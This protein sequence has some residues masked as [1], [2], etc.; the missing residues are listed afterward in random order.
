MEQD[1]AQGDLDRRQKFIEIANRRTNRATAAIKSIGH[2]SNRNN[3]EWTP[4]DW[5]QIKKALR[6][7]VNEV[8]RRFTSDGRRVDDIFELKP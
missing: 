2:L 5:R 6:D 8:D 7:A 3:Y 4:H 1:D